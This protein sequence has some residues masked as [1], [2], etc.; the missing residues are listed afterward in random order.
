MK[1]VFILWSSLSKLLTD[2]IIFAKDTLIDV[3]HGN[4][5]L[6]ESAL[7]RVPDGMLTF[8]KLKV[9]RARWHLGTLKKNHF[10]LS[11]ALA[12]SLRHEEVKLCTRF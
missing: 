2:F 7:Y 6:F 4:F 10:E 3:P 12:L 9:V 5:V 8:D 1:S 11:H